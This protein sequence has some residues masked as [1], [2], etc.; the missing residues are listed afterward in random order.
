[1][2][3]LSI[4]GKIKAEPRTGPF[5][6]V[7]LT[8]TIPVFPLECADRN[9]FKVW[10]FNYH[11]GL[12]SLADGR[13]RSIAFRHTHPHFEIF[14]VSKGEGALAVNC[15]L[16]EVKPRSLVIIGP[17]D[18]HVWQRTKHLEGS[19]LSVSEAFTSG[20]D[21]S[22]PFGELTSLLRRHQSRAFHLNAGDNSLM[23]SFFE[24]LGRPDEH[25]SFYHPAV[26]RALLLILC[27]NMNGAQ[28]KAASQPP[29]VPSSNLTRRFEQAL[30]TECPRLATVKEFAEHLKVSRSYLH[31]RVQRET[32]KAPG[33]LI[34]DRIVFEGKR[35]LIHTNKSPSQIAEHLGFR[36]PAY[37]SSFFKRHTDLSP[38]AFRSKSAA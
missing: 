6:C 26:L 23:R 8:G 19:A 3:E 33:D 38:R 35:L 20:S 36:T 5:D 21:F 18:I 15:N 31:R 10:Q 32:G 1:M 37:F 13:H 14:L 34:R 2:L 11:D 4:P 22:L 25:W 17:G 30:L 28:E 24:V 9:G 16:I 12:A 27:S 29:K 7:P